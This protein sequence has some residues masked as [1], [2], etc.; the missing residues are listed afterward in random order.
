MLKLVLF[1]LFTACLQA[2]P[3]PASASKDPLER[4]SPQSS[5]FH[6][7]E[8]CHARDYAKAAHY[9]DLQR[10]D[11]ADRATRGP[12]LARQLEDLLD[13]TPFD[14]ATLS[15][16]PDGDQSDGLAADLEVLDTF[17]L[18]GKKLTL[19][20]ERTPLKNG[21]QVW[22]VAP[23]AVA[24]IPEAHTLVVETPFEKKLP[25][26]LVTFEILDTPVWRWMALIL[27]GLILWSVTGLFSRAIG[28]LIR[29]LVSASDLIKPIRALLAVV[30][31]RGTLDL[32]A[33][34][35]L[36]RLYIERALGLI[37]S[38]SLAWAATEVIDLLAERWHSRLDPRMQAVTFSVLPLGQQMVKLALFLIA[39]LSVISA[40]G[41]NTSTILAGLGVGGIAV[42][43]AAQKTLENLFGGISVIGDRP[44]L[45]GD[46]CKFGDRIGTVM[47][48]GLRSTRIRTPDRTVISV[49][50]GQFSS[51]ALENL[52]EQDKFWFHPTFKL[53]RDT[54]PAQ[55]QKVLE[56]MRKILAETPNVEAGKIPVHFTA[57]AEYSLNVEVVAYIA[58]VDGD[59]FLEVQQNL[60]IKMLQ[61]VEQAGTA[62]AVPLQESVNE[63]VTKPAGSQ[64]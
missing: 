51:M 50:N 30:V 52:S 1:F 4:T 32:A 21:P 56:S 11:S 62:L 22:L 41:Y 23:S 19:Q 44:V 35:A 10:L 26:S 43:L 55:L 46:V 8:A 59:Q 63:D 64:P 24:L 36:P 5:V 31:F 27:I 34:S 49:P 61:A 9:L 54:S 29:P 28:A 15:R 13:D 42:A 58:T 16:D 3:V 18:D 20:L 17:T 60:L 12:D 37:F 7:L 25:Q 2:Q 48:I 38:L 45:V 14:I 39:I 40:W 57:V 47:H 53:R 6:F 33:P